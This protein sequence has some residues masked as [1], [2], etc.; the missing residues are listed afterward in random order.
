[1]KSNGDSP[2]YSHVESVVPR[3]RPHWHAVDFMIIMR[4]AIIFDIE[5][6]LIYRR[7][8]WF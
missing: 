1:M 7:E 5:I 2:A 4:M 8:V 6:A 3:C